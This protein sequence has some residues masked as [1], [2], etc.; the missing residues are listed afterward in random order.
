MN[1]LKFQIP[2]AWGSIR[3]IFLNLCSEYD[4]EFEGLLARPSAGDVVQDAIICT[5]FWLVV[6]E[7]WLNFGYII[8][9]TSRKI[10]MNLL[11]G[12]KIEFLTTSD[13]G[14]LNLSRMVI[15]S[16]RWRHVM[17]KKGQFKFIICLISYSLYNSKKIFVQ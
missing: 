14:F 16:T 6:I 13:M 5:Q 8:L 1:L 17:S 4:L 12:S 3:V 10:Y 11:C 15:F 7:K 9:I 2:T